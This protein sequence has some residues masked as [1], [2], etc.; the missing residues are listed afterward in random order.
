MNVHPIIESPRRWVPAVGIALVAIAVQVG[1]LMRYAEAAWLPALADGVCAVALF[2]ALAY[3][4]WFVV[5]YVSLIQTDV[6]TAVLVLLFW[7]AG[8]F[9]VQQMLEQGLHTVYAPYLV[10]LP[11]RLLV[12]LL[13]WI[14]V[15]L[16]YRL[17]ALRASGAEAEDAAEERELQLERASMAEPTA[18]EV[19][20][21]TALGGEASAEEVSV[22]GCM[23]RIAVKNGARIHLIPT[24]ELLYIQACGDYV[25]LV[26][27]QG[28]H[29]KEQTMKYFEAHL[30][31]AGFVRIHRSTI[32]NVTQISRVELF[33]KENYQLLLKN[34]AKL[35]VS[36][37]GY[38]LL[39]ERLEL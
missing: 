11:F 10:T 29:V 27:A 22:A 21:E 38:R 9:A 13:C 35:R 30:P 15:M 2:G 20:I 12:G 23:D 25:T 34:G 17:Q 4:S 28:Q 5:G 1:L 32:V 26:T 8:G 31:A 18:E 36:H 24:H 14:G 16:W 33:G 3:L 6:V 7:L 19:L 39:K 37:S